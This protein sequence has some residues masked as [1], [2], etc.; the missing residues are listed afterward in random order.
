MKVVQIVTRLIVGGAQRV[1]LEQADLVREL[2]WESALWFGPQ[3]GPEGSLEAEARSRGIPM[4]VF[5]ELVKEVSPLRD[6]R[7]LVAL[8][9]ALRREGAAIVHTHSSKAGI[10]GR[11]A[12]R[13]ARVPAIVHT[14]HGWGWHDGTAPVLRSLYARAERVAAR[15]C[16]RLVAVSAAVRR[17]GLARGIGESSLYEVI[18][19]GIDT[20]PFEDLVALR[21][22]GERIRRELGIPQGRPVAG[23]VG[24]LSPQKNPCMLID[25]IR[26]VPDLHLLLVGDGPLR[27]ALERHALELGLA[28]RV[29]FAGL[30]A[31]PAPWYAAM[32]VFVLTSLWEGLPLTCIE[33]VAA[34]I[35]ILAP[36]VAGVPEVVPPPPAGRVLPPGDVPALESA[37]RQVV[38]DL[39]AARA[40]VL[41]QRDRILAAH[42]RETML[43]RVADL[44]RALAGRGEMSLPPSTSN[45]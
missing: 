41:A 19:P 30:Q 43:R 37:L 20:R 25:A 24:R 33:A 14:V 3:T 34:G 35:P 5:P 4:R 40:A 18:P 6:L 42:S 31:D 15:R 29:H 22:R 32:D 23:S 45:L 10:L 11:H 36:E 17:E 2:G 26:G 27:G 13:K 9:A 39:P 38:D 7:A 1:A 21:A 12:A 16:N 44:Y 28:E 8:T